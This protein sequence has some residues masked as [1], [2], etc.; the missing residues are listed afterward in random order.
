MAQKI[1]FVVP[2]NMINKLIGEAGKYQLDITGQQYDV[3]LSQGK[4]GSKFLAVRM[5]T[6]VKQTHKRERELKRVGVEPIVEL[7]K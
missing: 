7:G 6:D 4:N 5:E 2:T 3:Y 1:S